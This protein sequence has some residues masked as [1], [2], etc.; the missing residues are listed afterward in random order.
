[1]HSP[2]DTIVGIAHAARIYKLAIHPKSFISLEGADHFLT[3]KVDAM[4]VGSIIA[5]WA[6]RYII[7]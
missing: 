3:K 4:Y 1:M 7:H 5:I 2:Q 6:S